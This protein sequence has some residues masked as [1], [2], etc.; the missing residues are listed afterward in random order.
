MVY[1]KHLRRHEDC[2]YVSCLCIIVAP[3]P[4]FT[5]FATL[6]CQCQDLALPTPSDMDPCVFPWQLYLCATFFLA[7]TGDL[8]FCWVETIPELSSW[9][10]GMES[11][12]SCSPHLS[13]LP[14]KPAHSHHS[15]WHSWAWEPPEQP[16]LKLTLDLPQMWMLPPPWMTNRSEWMTHMFIRILVRVLWTLPWDKRSF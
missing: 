10:D 16:D 7:H 3:F 4:S 6:W 12:P 9:D 8:S 1:W 15:D 14:C 11:A 13:K 2:S 5:G